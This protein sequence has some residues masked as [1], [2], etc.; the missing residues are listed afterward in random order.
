ML[1]V[2][3]LKVCKRIVLSPHE[4]TYNK[5]L[6][7]VRGGG[8]APPNKGPCDDRLRE[9]YVSRSAASQAT[10]NLQGQMVIQQT[11]VSLLFE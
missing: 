5:D 2:E 7:A 1:D 8:C 4:K 9:V 3:A 6:R 10:R 11:V